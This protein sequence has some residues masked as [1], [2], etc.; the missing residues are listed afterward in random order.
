M[1]QIRHMTNCSTHEIRRQQ[2]GAWRRFSCKLITDLP[3]D[4]KFWEMDFLLRKQQSAYFLT[5]KPFLT[6]LSLQR[7]CTFKCRSHS[8]LRLVIHKSRVNKNNQFKELLNNYNYTR[9]QALIFLQNNILSTFC[10][11]VTIGKLIYIKSS[12]VWSRSVS[13]FI[14]RLLWCRI[15]DIAH[16]LSLP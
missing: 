2:Q 11:L 16:S 8:P 13:P 4:W 10:M 1:E 5:Q 15:C 6:R 3:A 9:K 14:Q 12:T 7:F